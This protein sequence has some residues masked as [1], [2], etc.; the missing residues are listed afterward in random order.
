MTPALCFVLLPSGKR[1][2]SNGAMADFEA[3]YQDLVVPA[4]RQAGLEPYRATDSV[5]GAMGRKALLERFVLCEFAVADLTGTDANFFLALGERQAARRG[6]TVLLFSEGTPLPFEIAPV[7]MVSYRLSA[8]GVPDGVE[9]SKS[10]ITAALGEARQAAGQKSSIVQ[11]VN[12]F[13]GIAH[14]KTDL[15]RDRVEYSTALKQRLA[16]ARRQGLQ[17]V[18][19]VEQELGEIAGQESGVIIDLLLSYRA[20]KGWP[21]MIELVDKMSPPLRATVMVQE[22]FAF[23]LNRNQQGERAEQVLKAV[24]ESHGP[25][26]ET[27]SLLGRVYKDRWEAALTQGQQDRARDWLDQAIG[28]YLRG[29]EADWRDALPGINTVTLMTLREPPDPRREQ[30][31]P[32]VSY[33]VERRIAGGKPDY[34]DYASRLEIAVLAKHEAAATVALGQALAVVREPW[35]PETTARNLRLIREARQRRN[36]ALPWMQKIEQTL[37]QTA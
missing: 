22:Q 1:T 27:Y 35:E 7:K 37:E 13:H 34:W 16:E 33:A 14:T 36:S 2:A 3:V 4:V 9:A 32:V 31:L 23:A 24:L 19:R 11:L 17:A 10:A 8:K 30:L 28:A 12:V 15:F 26:S 21:Q 20:A 6:N 18:G 5:N 25:S 29:F